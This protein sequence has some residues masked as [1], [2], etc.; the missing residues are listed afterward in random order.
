MSEQAMRT[1]NGSETN[2]GGS[3]GRTGARWP[4]CAVVRSATMELTPLRSGDPAFNAWIGSLPF[5]SALCGGVGDPAGRSDRPAWR[6][7]RGHPRVERAGERD[8]ACPFGIRAASWGASRWAA[9]LVTALAN[10]VPGRVREIKDRRKDQMMVSWRRAM[11]HQFEIVLLAVALFW[12][13]GTSIAQAQGK[14][15]PGVSDVEIKIGQTMPYSGPVS[16]LS[17]FGKSEAAYFKMINERGGI[18][19]RRITFISLDDNYSPAKTMEQTRRLV[20]QDN[21]LAIMGSLGT[22]TNA[23]IQKYLNSNHVPHLFIQT[24]ASRWNDPS[25]FPWTMSLIYPARSEAVLAARYIMQANP[26]A[27]IAVLYQNDDFGRDYVAGLVEGMGPQ[28]R[29]RI[30]AKA[31]YEVTD[32]TVDSQIVL[33]R[34]S[35]ADTIFIAATPRSTAQALRK[36][37]EI[38]WHP[39]RFVS[40]AS[41]SVTD[42]LAAVG[43]EKSEG[44]MTTTS[45]KSVGDPQWANDP[46]YLAWL[47]FMR[48]YYPGG[49][50]N[51]K[52][53]FLGYSN[54]ALFAEVLRRCGDDLTRENLLAVA[55][56]LEGVHLP[57]LLPG[58]TL[59]TSPTD[60]IPIKHIRLQRFDGHRW[61]LL[62]DLDEK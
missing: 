17:V 27:H 4:I 34:S 37:F 1:A 59:S 11:I 26:Y 53:A 2:Q 48:A 47:D 29:S 32:P 16:A 15:G 8:R 46:D 58:I 30:V 41:S 22:A 55:T 56:H 5:L 45:F 6:A 25:H 20:E 39:T 61:V 3:E 7:H 33:L 23:A 54:A 57:A 14:Y 9:P 51:D 36:V 31:S 40:Q 49:D 43:L 44:V 13:D 24:V 19:G 21:V 62:P 35:G 12:V 18:N 28:A 38:H 50:I 52:F 10:I 60:Y 42:V